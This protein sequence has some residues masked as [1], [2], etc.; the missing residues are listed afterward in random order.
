MANGLPELKDLKKKALPDEGQL[1][2]KE[3]SEG[4]ESPSTTV[5]SVPSLGSQEATADNVD[6]SFLNKT[7]TPQD[8]GFSVEPQ[9]DQLVEEQPK[10]FSTTYDKV[11]EPITYGLNYLEEL[12]K[13]FEAEVKES[14]PYKAIEDLSSQAEALKED[15]DNTPKTLETQ[16]QVDAANAKV[17]QYNNLLSQINKLS[18][19]VE[20]IGSDYKKQREDILVGIASKLNLVYPDTE[21]LVETEDG[22]QPTKEFNRVL[23]EETKKLLDSQEYQTSEYGFGSFADTPLAGFNKMFYETLKL[24]FQLTSIFQESPNEAYQFLDAQARL[25]NK[26]KADAKLASLTPEQ[27]KN[28]ISANIFEKGDY[29]AAALNFTY[30]L[31]GTIPQVL[32]AAYSPNAGV[33]NMGRLAIINPA[34]TALTAPSLKALGKD[35]FNLGVMAMANEKGQD[36]YKEAIESGLTPAQATT[37][38]TFKSLATLMS[39]SIFTSDL[40]KLR[41]T[42]QGRSLANEI[43]ANKSKVI[44]DI[45]T[46]LPKEYLETG[47]E[48]ALEELF[49][50]IVDGTV[51]Y[52]MTGKPINL[53]ELTDQAVVGLGAGGATSVKSNL[54]QLLSV[55]RTDPKQL[56]AQKELNNILQYIQNN[57]DLDPT[58]VDSLEREAQRIKDNIDAYAK[59]KQAGLDDLSD[60]DAEKYVSL[61][62]EIAN[63][64]DII[65]NIDD[66]SAKASM[67]RRTQE[68]INEREA[69]V[70]SSQE[71][72]GAGETIEFDTEIDA[73]TDAV[74]DAVDEVENVG[75]PTDIKLAKNFRKAANTA[76]VPIDEA[77]EYIGEDRV[78]DEALPLSR[79]RINE[80]KEDIRKNGLKEALIMFYND[81]EASIIEGNHRIQALKELGYTEVPIELRTD[82]IPS[83]LNRKETPIDAF[84][85]RGS[86]VFDQLGITNKNFN[87]EDYAIQEQETTEVPVREQTEVSEE[88]GEEVRG[89]QESTEQSQEQTQGEVILKYEPTEIPSEFLDVDGGERVF[90]E[91]ANAYNKS[92][93]RRQGKDVAANNAAEYIKGTKAYENANDVQREAMIRSF[94]KEVG[95]KE[96]R[97]PSAA[98]ITGKPAD[99]KVTVNE[100]AALK[101]QIRLE[102]KAAKEGYKQA[103]TEVKDF[104]A[105]VKSILKNKD[106]I[107]K[108][109]LTQAQS[110]S[111]SRAATGVRTPSQMRRFL[112]T[113]NR[114]IESVDYANKLIEATS[115]RSKLKSGLDRLPSNVRSAIS[116]FGKINPKD[117]GNIDAYIKTANGLLAYKESPKADVTEEGVDVYVTD[118]III[119]DVNDYIDSYNKEV[120]EGVKKDLLEENKELKE[121]GVIDEEMSMADIEKILDAIDGDP[122]ATVFRDTEKGDR[123]REGFKRVIVGLQGDLKNTQSQ[124]ANRFEKEAK[125]GLE[126]VDVDQLSDSQL[127]QL[128]LAL[129]NATTN[130]RFNG[131]HKFYSIYEAQQGI[132]KLESLYKKAARNVYDLDFKIA[133]WQNV[134]KAMTGSS[135]SAAEVR[136]LMGIEAISNGRARAEQRTK[137][138]ED[139]VSKLGSSL[140][141]IMGKFSTLNETSFLSVYGTLLT[142]GVENFQDFKKILRDIIDNDLKSSKK[143]ERENAKVVKEMFDNRIAPHDSLKNIP[144]TA[145]ERKMIDVFLDEFAK[146]KPEFKNLSETVYNIEFKDVDNYLPL[147]WRKRSQEDVSE[148]QASS[149]YSNNQVRQKKDGSL[150][151]RTYKVDPANFTL[152]FDFIHAMIM[153]YKS[154][155][156]DIETAAAIEKYN[157]FYRDPRSAKAMGGQTNKSSVHNKMLDYVNSYMRFNNASKAERLL[158]SFMN[159]LAKLGARIRLG[160]LTQIF[161]QSIP[162]SLRATAIL[163]KDSDLLFDAAF[164]YKLKD[165]ANFR[166]LMEQFPIGTR[167]FLKQEFE[168]SGKKIS[169]SRKEGLKNLIKEV[170]NVSGEALDKITMYFLEQG[171]VGIAELTWTAF[172]LQN[173]RERGVYNGKETMKQLAD[174][175]DEQAAA[176]AEQMVGETQVPSDVRQSGSYFS[177]K[178]DIVNTSR[179]ILFP[180]ISFRANQS[181]SIANSIQLLSKGAKK[182]K[183]DAGKELMGVF[184]ENSSF[185]LISLLRYNMS[186]ALAGALL[187]AMGIDIEE[188]DEE[189]KSMKYQTWLAS[190]IGRTIAEFNPMYGYIEGL[191]SF[192]SEQL[193]KFYFWNVLNDE[194]RNKYLNER[195]LASAQRKGDQKKIEMVKEK[196][197]NNFLKSK[198]EPVPDFSKM[199]KDEGLL[200]IFGPQL[201][202]SFNTFEDVVE[203]VEMSTEETY[204]YL[205]NWNSIT[206]KEFSDKEKDALLLSAI[207]QST[208]FVLPKELA[209]VGKRMKSEVAY[210]DKKKKSKRPSRSR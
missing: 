135:K 15:I 144:I 2:K 37:S 9:Q 41:G 81:G 87:T 60:E 115:I 100:R 53:Y 147:L 7:Y 59:D 67:E 201:S 29:K 132:G 210:G 120:E 208:N 68:L 153:K 19:D 155:V 194:Q 142:V 84:Q 66:E 164:K 130:F 96:K 107:P 139:K 56:E 80:L 140:F 31:L 173:L 168:S 110:K 38:A 20:G 105:R 182:E 134:F 5:P 83:R 55:I 193:N 171:D 159:G 185:A 138:L 101:D 148:L 112:E 23:V 149:S 166:R 28:G 146:I 12:D 11:V 42:A 86:Y 202:A 204:R 46:K 62:Q 69:L 129:Q 1:K 145:L 165:K 94:R 45:I 197:F 156:S 181:Y 58:Q 189:E 16:E 184:A 25:A 85:Q 14:E 150:N 90:G 169:K 61:S 167:G 116:D 174:N 44:K 24:P 154:Q 36:S 10:Q 161:A 111:L 21:F 137:E 91:A 141:G 158:F 131:A 125:E 35:G 104:A 99:K 40:Q 170:Y 97:A 121:Q 180:F 205:N 73:E 179:R 3:P 162:V 178:D 190:T 199:K 128:Y 102:V 123:K 207:L 186:L 34:R 27:I 33:N 124:T 163:G 188:D 95:V 79:E 18:S 113:A 63:N 76:M 118:P 48:E 93:D 13:G 22:L 206:E 196:A 71:K 200:G 195:E 39:E 203:T 143:S 77:L 122:E 175:P 198:F 64:L 177:S 82:P 17:E 127:S 187:S 108:G 65:K 26:V 8:F 136:R 92:L 52:L 157:A 103:V 47:S 183:Q 126:K 32:V 172:Y 192:S 152:D 6:L 74:S 191:D 4:M 88:V 117:V 89:E 49:E 30:D 106:F 98:K 133:N 72:A 176:Y 57:P 43:M 70:K 119:D 75:E 151:E 114:I 51:D 78:G 54:S 209:D 109:I 160:G 50:G